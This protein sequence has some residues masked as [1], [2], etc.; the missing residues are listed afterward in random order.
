MGLL[1][2]VFIVLL[3]L[4][5]PIH[6]AYESR[7]YAARSRAGH[8]AERSRLYRQTALLEWVFFA[9]L[10]A[11]WLD[12]GRPMADL[13]L[14]MSWGPGFWSGLAFCLALT[15]YLLYCWQSVKNASSARRAELAKSLGNAV[16]FVPHTK[17]ELRDFYL[18]SITAGIV[19]EIVY[20]GFVIWYLSLFM[21]V[22]GAVVASSIAFGLGHTY[23][24]P[25]GALRAGLVGLAL[26][27]LY[28][29]TGSIW[30]PIVA[31]VL[32][33]VLQGALFTELL[34]EDDKHLE[35]Q[36]V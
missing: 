19:E 10:A 18:V 23:Q 29:V 21:P 15:G 30:L 7:Y 31:H 16:D 6:G 28:V 36:A 9:L 22:W 33:D 12:S 17:R 35:P 4:L 34:G 26:A 13:G 1:D 20:R 5:Q 25:V 8:P 14:V 2:H 11:A 32:I 27:V 3:F 24:G